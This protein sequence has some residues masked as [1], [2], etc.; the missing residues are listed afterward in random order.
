M[1]KL[2]KI[3][4]VS[5][6]ISMLFLVRAF[7]DKLFYDPLLVYFENNY[8][9][10][11]LP[12]LEVGR[13]Y[14]NLFFRFSINSIISLGILRVLFNKRSY[15]IFASRF[16]VFSFVILSS[17]LLLYLNLKIEG[18]YLFL[19]YLRRFL[20]QP[21]FVFLLIPAFYYQNRYQ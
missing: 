4:L 2:T 6:L 9:N 15:I 17:L 3:V 10:S 18:D 1:K 12:K 19:F 21:L 16:Y 7:Q 13:Y 11:E 5:V 8:L 14:L 20:I